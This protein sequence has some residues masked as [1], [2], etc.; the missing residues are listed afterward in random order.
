MQ[1]EVPVLPVWNCDTQKAAERSSSSQK[2]TTSVPDSIQTENICSFG[3]W[4]VLNS[5][6]CPR[7]QHTASMISRSYEA[8][9]GHSHEDWFRLEVR[10]MVEEKI[11]QAS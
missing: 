7:E 9:S 1:H 8:I 10:A 4:Q 11:L 2:F 5:D 3:A 6:A